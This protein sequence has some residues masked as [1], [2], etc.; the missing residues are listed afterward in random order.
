MAAM[1]QMQGA[2]MK[3]WLAQKRGELEDGSAA[4]S[5]IKQRVCVLHAD[6]E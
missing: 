3:K 4:V 5:H 1:G 6:V 2:M